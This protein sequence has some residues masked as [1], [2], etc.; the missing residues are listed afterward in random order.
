MNSNDWLTPFELTFRHTD[1]TLERRNLGCAKKEFTT[2]KIRQEWA[3]HEELLYNTVN[4]AS[5]DLAEESATTFKP[6]E[7]TK[8]ESATGSQMSPDAAAAAGKDET[9]SKKKR[10]K[11]S[12]MKKKATQRKSSSS[13]SVGS[14]QSDQND[15]ETDTVSLS[16]D[17]SPKSEQADG[18]IIVASAIDSKETSSTPAKSETRRVRDMEIHFFSDTELASAKSPSRPSTPIQ[19]DSELEISHRDKA[20][21]TDLM[22][23]SASWKWGELPT[24]GNDQEAITEDAKQA[25]RTS[26]INNIFSFMKQSKKLQK[27][28]IEGV[29]L[30]DL[31]TQGMDPE[32]AAMYFP[33]LS[34]TEVGMHN[35]FASNEDDRESGNGTSLPHSPSSMEGLKSLDSDYDDG[36]AGDK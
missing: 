32:V 33:S 11:K 4:A 34:K 7:S 35:T 5:T 27:N 28:S 18:S 29:Y 25:Q 26:M 9:K 14:T 6:I 8:D 24:Q 31:D 12:M 23:G 17:D 22:T 36:K 20:E 10:R 13:S 30:S 1:N 16:I 21:N 19:S 3:E 15:P 2:Q